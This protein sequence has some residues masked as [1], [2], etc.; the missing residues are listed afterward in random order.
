MLSSLSQKLNKTFQKLRGKGRI[1]E[2]DVDAALREVRL[3]LL[4]AD[5]NFRIV[6]DFIARVREKAI[7]SSVLES[8]SPDQ[9]VVAIVRDELTELLGGHAQRI[10][11]SSQPPTVIMLAGLQGTGKTTTCAKLA[12]H[13]KREGK[14]PLLVA[15]DIYRPGAILQLQTVG[16]Q[17]GVP[18][19]EMGQS[20][21]PQIA[22]ASLKYADQHGLDVVILDTA[23]RLHID[24]AMMAE[25]RAVQEVAKPQEVLL[26]LD[27][28]TGQDAVNAAQ[29]FHDTIPL[30]GVVLT[31]LDGDARGGAIL[32]VRAV[33][34]VPVKFVGVGEKLDALEAFHP[35]RMAGRILGMGDVLTLIEKAEKQFDEKQAAA[36][37]EK[38]LQGNFDLEDF[39]SQMQEVKKMGPLE[40]ILGMIPGASRVMANNP[41]VAVDEKQMARVE[42]IIRSMTPQERRDPEIINGSRK[43]RI[44]AGS[45]TST[46]EINRLLGQFRDMKK[47]LRQM[48]AMASGKTKMPRGFNPMQFMR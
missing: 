36:M 24:E 12:G 37:E 29:A 40:N 26:A 20:P 4:E 19:F 45:G 2:A 27:A 23:G 47:M 39:L 21:P 41:S 33:T 18:V 35:D 14:K 30:T 25:V 38:L 22:K 13:L 31:K 34:G 32:S 17:V 46:Q 11:Y 43:R 1:T 3:A 8:L 6:K 48:Q 28:M 7:G 42:A 9:Q 44:A 16:Q 15:C 5:V 10:Q